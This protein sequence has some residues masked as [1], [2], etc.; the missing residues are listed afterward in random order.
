MS[1]RPSYLPKAAH[2]AVALSAVALVVALGVPGHAGGVLTGKDIKN[3]TISG[4][5]IK[6]DALKG[7]DVLE[8]SLALSV[9]GAQVQDHS[10]TAADYALASGQKA[11]TFGDIAAG[12]CTYTN[13][14]AGVDLTGAVV[15]VMAPVAV[16]FSQGIEV[17][18]QVSTVAT[19]FN[20]VACNRKSSGLVNVPASTFTW[21]ALR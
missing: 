8:S 6:D 21:I 2:L 4:K 12:F 7:S 1:Q 19:A 15:E 20:L 18:A 16:E 17:Y 10:L 14:P 3:G 9:G 13:V 11:F 5:D